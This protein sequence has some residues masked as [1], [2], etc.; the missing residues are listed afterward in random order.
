[1]RCSFWDM[2]N[3][4]PTHTQREN[5][6]AGSNR[7]LAVALL[8]L[9]AI[10]G[11]AFFLT[12]VIVTEIFGPGVAPPVSFD[13]SE[14]TGADRLKMVLGLVLFFA[15]Y[16]GAAFGPVLLPL[17]GWQAFALARAFG[18]RSKASIWAWT[19]V[20]L[21]VVAAALFWGWLINLDIF[22]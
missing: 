8:S 13:E 3:P 22:I 9:P 18:A 11:T 14:P 16:F 17:A 15:C 5:P 6:S 1:M 12:G 10:V 2:S 4:T 19:F 20:V 7:L 21:G